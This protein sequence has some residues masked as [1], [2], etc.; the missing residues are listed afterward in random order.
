MEF[1]PKTLSYFYLS[2]STPSPIVATLLS[3]GTC[4][5]V[6]LPPVIPGFGWK[7]ILG[8]AAIILTACALLAGFYP[9]PA[10]GLDRADTGAANGMIIH[11]GENLPI[12]QDRGPE[13]GICGERESCRPAQISKDHK[14][15]I[16]ANLCPF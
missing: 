5:V 1:P 11:P 12:T 14:R 10:R 15:T 3:A 16:P 7:L 6:L 13:N 2:T 9:C 8:S 4:R